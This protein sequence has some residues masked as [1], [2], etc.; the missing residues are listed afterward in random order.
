MRRI[1]RSF[2]VNNSMPALK[3]FA[4]IHP[5]TPE[6]LHSFQSAF[7]DIEILH[8]ESGMPRGFEQAQAA[9]VHWNVNNFAGL[10]AAGRSLRWLHIRSTGV[11]QL[12]AAA[13]T[14][15]DVTLTN[16]SGNHAP[17]IAEHVLA[18]MFAFARQLPHFVRAQDRREWKPVRS[19]RVFELSEQHVVIVGLGSIGL[20]L[21]RRAKALGMRVTGVR[22]RAAMP[23]PPSVD[24]VCA[25]FDVDEVLTKADHVVLALP[26]TEQSIQLFDKRRL[27]CIKPGAY[28]YN[29]G[30]GQTVDH[31]ALVGALASGH[32]AG[33]GLDV[34]YPE[35][36]PDNSPLWVFPNVLLTAHTAGATPRSYQRFEAL[37][38]E[39]MRRFSEDRP[40]LNV[41]DKAV[42][43]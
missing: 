23:L 42:G 32:I 17:N 33:A 12:A 3:T 21:A 41:V 7:P 11:E 40:L 37:V 8:A 27:A 39:N 16:G 20:E 2:Q 4:L 35:P 36:L 18:M 5:L 9:A 10:L 6:Q 24:E 28:L 19:D 1:D 34:T 43:Y 13:Q 15:R 31:D 22:R 29:V 26:L 38:M 25:I 14:R 30:R